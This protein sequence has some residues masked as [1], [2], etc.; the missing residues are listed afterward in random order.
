[1]RPQGTLN[2]KDLAVVLACLFFLVCNLAAFDQRGRAH[3]KK[4]VCLAN[5]RQLAHAWLLYAGD[6]DDQIVNGARGFG[7]Y[8]T[9][10]GYHMHEPA[11]VDRWSASPEGTTRAIRDG[12]LWPYLKNDRVYRCPAARRDEMLTYSIVFSMNAVC[13]PEVYG[14]PGA[15]VKRL[16]EIPDPKQRLV[17][18]DQGA[19]TSTAFAVYC[20]R[21]LWLDSPPIRHSDGMT[22]SFADGHSEHWQWNGAETVEK[23]WAS[24]KARLA[25]WSPETEPGYQ[26][27]YRIQKGCWGALGY[28]PSYVPPD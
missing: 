7:N 1:M 26:D 15:H 10:W 6:N 22:A 12:A 14:V 13:H 19:T 5:T 21:E 16:D 23:G 25:A 27:L 2:K 8:V 11:W 9:S 18:V 24:E 17:F 28:A 20:A 3:A 4:I